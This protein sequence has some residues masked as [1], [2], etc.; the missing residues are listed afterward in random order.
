LPRWF[1]FG[2]APPP[3]NAPFLGGV[4]P[5]RQ[6]PRPAIFNQAGHLQTRRRLNRQRAPS[7]G[8]ASHSSGEAPEKFRLNF[9]KT[10]AHLI[11]TFPPTAIASRKLLQMLVL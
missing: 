4:H 6:F 11:H 2:K 1:I 5:I 7:K 3:S 8:V 9:P 10:P